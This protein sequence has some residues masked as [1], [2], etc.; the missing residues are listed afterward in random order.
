MNI[1]STLFGRVRPIQIRQLIE[2]E[3]PYGIYECL[4]SYETILP[5]NIIFVNNLIDNKAYFGDLNATICLSK[6]AQGTI[7]NGYTRD[8]SRL[9][10]LKYPVYYKNNT[11]C[12]VK[13]F[14]TLDYYD[15]PININD[16]KIYVN[17]LIFADKD[18]IIVIPK[19]VESILIDKCKTILTQENNISNSIITGLN[20][21]NII[22]KYGTF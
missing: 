19:H 12:D 3:D 22:E 20:I 17:N 15:K 9:V 8:V 14:G 6:K 7:V 2:N 1:E 10:S 13:N 18:G 11:C 16:V 21:Q 4:K 5:G